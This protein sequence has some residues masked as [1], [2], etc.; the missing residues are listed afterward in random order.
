MCIWPAGGAAAF[1]NALSPFAMQI[2]GSR[3]DRDTSRAHLYSPTILPIKVWAFGGGNGGG[4]LHLTIHTNLIASHFTHIDYF[5]TR[6]SNSQLFREPDGG[7][8]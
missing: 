3:G 2:T 4:C 7:M 6:S 5:T 1:F 8:G